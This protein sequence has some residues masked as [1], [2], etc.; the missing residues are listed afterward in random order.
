MENKAYT[1]GA[2]L[3]V[4]LLLVLLVGA[5]LW[6]NN[7]GHLE[8]RLYDLVTRSSVAGL[9][10]GATVSLR[11]VQIGEVQSIQFDQEDPTSIR[12]RV[13][14]DPKIQL[15]QGSYGT[16]SSQGL[17]GDAY[18]DLDFPNEAREPL[19]SPDLNPPRIPLRPSAWAQLPASGERFLTSFTDTL[20]R[21]DSIL[22]P[23]NAQRLSRMLVDFSAAA[24]QI[25]AVAHDLR[26]A[27]ER[28]AQTVTDADE[29]LRAARQTLVN[30]NSLVTDVRARVGVLDEVGEGMRQTGLA[31]RGVEG[32]LVGS[33]LPKVD[34][35]LDG[36]SQNSETLEELLKQIKQQPQSVVFGDSLPPLGPGESVVRTW[37][38]KP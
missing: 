7:R 14:V 36:L 16:L 22:T 4:L 28:S 9:T 31:A 19:I 15:R 11:G 21:V 17:T 13:R 32:A 38:V 37:P 18:V 34:S 33:S 27:A 10:V 5:I 3:F 23:D 6:F 1:I 25:E 29:A 26:P 35:L 8:G 30:A 24:E 12:V 20:G 2:G